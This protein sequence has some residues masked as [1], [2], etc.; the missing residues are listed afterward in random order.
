MINL[1][2]FHDLQAT[3]ILRIRLLCTRQVN[4]VLNLTVINAVKAA[5]QLYS[6]ASF[7]ERVCLS[8]KF[9]PALFPI[10]G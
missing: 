4:R 10:F 3:S 8:S 5:P 2:I 1:A 6:L 9:V 7:Q